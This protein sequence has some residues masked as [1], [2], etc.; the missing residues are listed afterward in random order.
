MASERNDI[1]GRDDIDALMKEFYR[2]AFA[3]PAIGYIF[4]D[5]AKMDLEEHLPVI[6]DFWEGILFGAR[7]YVAR[8]RNPMAIH[9]QLSDKEPLRE[10]H[11]IRWLELFRGAVDRLFNGPNAENIKWRAA[12]IAD[13]M[14]ANICSHSG[15]NLPGNREAVGSLRE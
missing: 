7:K 2:V 9:R 12:Q 4:T 1:L 15:F 14:V 5:I 13:R 8:G 11:F 3:D 6:G 10:E